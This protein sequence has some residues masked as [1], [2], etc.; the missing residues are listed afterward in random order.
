MHDALCLH[1]PV[2]ATAA[3]GVQVIARVLA[4]CEVVRV[5]AAGRA[6]CVRQV[7]PV[8][9]EVVSLGGAAATSGCG[10]GPPRRGWWG[11]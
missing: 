3:L 6:V 1:D 5:I 8:N 10:G 2:T 7:G 11:V 4:V 9:W